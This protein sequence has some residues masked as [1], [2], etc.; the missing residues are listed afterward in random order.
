MIYFRPKII[1]KIHINVS[2]NFCFQMSSYFTKFNYTL[3]LTNSIPIYCNNRF[4]VT[5]CNITLKIYKKYTISGKLGAR[6]ELNTT[7]FNLSCCFIS[8]N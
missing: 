8:T 1:Q 5:I 6:G 7:D 4:I 3:S 2:L